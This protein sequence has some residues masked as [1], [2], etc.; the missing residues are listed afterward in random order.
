MAEVTLGTARLLPHRLRLAI[1]GRQGLQLLHGAALLAAL[2]L[3]RTAVAAELGQ[4][5]R[6]PVQREDALGAE[7][8]RQ[9]ALR[10]K[11]NRA[12]HI[13]LDMRPAP[14]TIRQAPPGGL[15]LAGLP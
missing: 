11:G 5:A 12:L 1:R 9:V 2:T 8:D 13:R 7:R 14:R 10:I 15:I 4:L 3:G 6:L